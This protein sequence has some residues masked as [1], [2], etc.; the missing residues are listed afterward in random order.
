M[1][2]D[3]DR[4]RKDARY[5]TQSWV[6]EVLG[7]SVVSVPVTVRTPDASVED[8]L[9][10]VDA[11]AEPPAA[12]PETPAFE[13]YATFEEPPRAASDQPDT[14]FPDVTFPDVTLP[15]MP[16]RHAAQRAPADTHSLFGDTIDP[17]DVQ[18]SFDS[19]TMEE[20]DSRPTIETM[21]RD[22]VQAAPLD[23]ES[24]DEFVQPVPPEVDAA[25]EAERPP[26]FVPKFRSFYNEIVL[27]KHQKSQFTGG[28]ATAIVDYTSDLSPDAAAQGLSKRLNEILELQHAEA[29]WMGGEAAAR[30]PDAQYAMAV[31]ADELFTYMEWPGQASWP[32]YLLEPRIFRT[33]AAE[34]EFFKRVDKLLKNEAENPSRA[35]KDLAR[36]YLLVLASGFKGKYRQPGLVR[37]LAEYRRRLYEFVS[38]QDPLM[39]YA[40]ERRIFPEATERTLE[41]KAIKRF[42]GLQQWAAALIVILVSYTLLANFAWK[43][44]SADLTDVTARVEAA[45]RTSNSGGAWST[46]VGDSLP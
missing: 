11:G 40:D 13:P 19:P 9:P 2:R 27:Y 16:M 6:V 15:D 29:M 30:Y 35:A 5:R 36:M 12:E 31:L 32:Q 7:D 26:F 23:D 34:V 45:N 8:A 21:A 46:A 33:R 20:I 1:E 25:A 28:F 22:T 41:S 38:G 14:S 42:S 4:A 39:L 3:L 10:S 43:R 17:G 24:T 18:P 37:P 44:V